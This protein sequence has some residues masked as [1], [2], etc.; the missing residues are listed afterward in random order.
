MRSKIVI[1]VQLTQITR[2]PVKFAVYGVAYH[3]GDVGKNTCAQALLKSV[4]NAIPI[5]PCSNVKR[6]KRNV[7]IHVWFWMSRT[8]L[9][10]A[11]HV[12]EQWEQ[13]EQR[14]H[15]EQR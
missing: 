5:L 7:V 8:I 4:N 15:R 3:P 1:V 13:R 12:L 6:V 11:K 2:Y 14:E 9:I 10:N